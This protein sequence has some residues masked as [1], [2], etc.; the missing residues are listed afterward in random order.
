MADVRHIENRFFG[1]N[2]AADRPISVKLCTGKQNSKMLDITWHKLQFLK[3]QDR[4]R[5]RFLK[6]VKTPYLSEKSSYVDEI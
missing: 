1:H 4:G 2:S 3:I 6:N 5:P